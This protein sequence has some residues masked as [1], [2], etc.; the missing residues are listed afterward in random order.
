I[1]AML[2]FQSFAHDAEDFAESVDRD[3]AMTAIQFMN[4][5]RYV[6]YEIADY[7][8]IF[9]LEDEYR[10]LSPDNLSLSRIPD[11]DIVQSIKDQLQALHE[12]RLEDKD[13]ERAQAQLLRMKQRERQDFWIHLGANVANSTL[14]SHDDIVVAVKKNDAGDRDHEAQR[15]IAGGLLNKT[16]SAYDNYIRIQREMEDSA[17]GSKF[18]FDVNR[19]NR[20]H[21]DNLKN[22]DFTMG[23]IRRY[24]IDDELRLTE[25]NAKALVSCVKTS[26]KAGAF[27]QLKVMAKHQPSFTHFPF[28]WCQY[29]SF[30][31]CSG[32]PKEALDACTK[33]ESENKYSLF[34]RDRLSAQAAMAKIQAMLELGMTNETDC[35]IIKDALLDITKYNYDSHDYD[36]AYYCA[37]IAHKILKDDNSALEILD[38]LIGEQERQTSDELVKYR[39]LFTKP[40]KDQKFEP[41]PML[42]DLFRCVALRT[43]I[44][45][46]DTEDALP[47]NLSA[48]FANSVVQGVERLFFVGDVRK[49]DLFAK[50]RSEINAIKLRYEMGV[51]KRDSFYA[52]IPA[53]W[54]ALGDFNVSLDLL[55][56]TNNLETIEDD[57][58][59]RSVLFDSAIHGGALVKAVFPRKSWFDSN[60]RIDGFRVIIPNSSWPVSILYRPSCNEEMT[61]VSVMFM[62]E[63]FIVADEEAAKEA[64]MTQLK[65]KAE[66]ESNGDEKACAAIAFPNDAGETGVIDLTSVEPDGKSLS[67]G[68]QKPEG[69]TGSLYI[70]ARFYN[71]FGAELYS[72]KDVVK[73]DAGDYG[74]IRL[75]CPAEM[76]DARTPAFILLSCER[77]K[78]IDFR[79]P[80]GKKKSNTN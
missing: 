69:F 27:A 8:N 42:S 51:F 60:S 57:S 26:N 74:T 2:A 25:E 28:F 39:D 22:F 77:K 23:L 79:I 5:L 33:F 55:C 65:R 37:G 62:G 59:K 75:D 1:F 64:T 76:K 15:R 32:H 80:W 16:I 17:E 31:V 30:A 58:S 38:G 7:N 29:A 56:N 54:F 41:V 61:P 66:S 73:N 35:A 70:S 36:M 78:K 10:N 40:R 4:Y 12:L 24:G 14:D 9:V 44:R 13:R 49:S 52:L 53:S 50:A 72:V 45:N 48:I 20:L 34:R 46:G 18:A 67:I 11:E 43:T 71:E 21:D 63:E 68:W 19:M 47:N 3:K 6:S